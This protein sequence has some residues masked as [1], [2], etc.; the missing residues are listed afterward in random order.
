MKDHNDLETYRNMQ[1]PFASMDEAEKAIEAFFDAVSLARK[2]NRIKDVHILLEIN[3]MDGET[4]RSAIAS[5][6]LGDSQKGALLCAWGLG[7]EQ[8]NF[9]KAIGEL[10][11]ES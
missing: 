8:K 7:Q 10:S 6:H 11:D 3:T 5:L 4:E 1:E 2:S 9:E